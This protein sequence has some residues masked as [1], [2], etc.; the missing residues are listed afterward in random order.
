MQIFITALDES[1]LP[2]S[3]LSHWN[4]KLESQVSFSSFSVWRLRQMTE[5]WAVQKFGGILLAQ[6]RLLSAGQ[7]SC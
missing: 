2:L 7:V 1:F 3:Y 4:L 5:K 6:K